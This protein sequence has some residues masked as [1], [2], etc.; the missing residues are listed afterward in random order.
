MNR[1]LAVRPRINRQLFS[2]LPAALSGVMLGHRFVYQLLFPESLHRHDV[3][4]ASNHG[5]LPYA[6][7]FAL[8]LLG[9]SLAWRWHVGRSARQKFEQKPS[10]WQAFIVLFVSQCLVF[11]A[12]ELGERFLS[13]GVHEAKHLLASQIL[14]LGCAL[15]VITAS[16]V[17]LV[18][19]GAEKLG[20]YFAQAKARRVQTA[21]VGDAGTAIHTLLSTAIFSIR[22][23]PRHSYN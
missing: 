5:Y 20:R 13:G 7:G 17:A 10:F 16:L 4:T 3:L 23:P 22:A 2:I 19:A 21:P 18:I 15:Q 14:V 1:S 6:T 8:G 12:L 11:I 9:L